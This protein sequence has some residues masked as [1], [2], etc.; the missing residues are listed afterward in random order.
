LLNLVEIFSSPRFLL[1]T[2]TN[3]KF[4]AHL[5]ETFSNILLYQ[6][7]SNSNLMFAMTR[8]AALFRALGMD[9]LSTTRFLTFLTEQLTL[10]PSL[11]AF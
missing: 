2:P 11:F 3:H 9:M 6:S 5:V 4:V 1:A 7:S 10:S 8:R